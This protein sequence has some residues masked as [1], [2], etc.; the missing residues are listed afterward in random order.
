MTLTTSHITR[1]KKN[2]LLTKFATKKTKQISDN[3]VT[4]FKNDDTMITFDEVEMIN[5]VLRK[6]KHETEVTFKKKKVDTTHYL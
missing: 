3:Q 2:N 6:N 5:P 1:Q 4:N